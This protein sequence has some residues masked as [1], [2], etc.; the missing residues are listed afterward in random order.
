MNTTDNLRFHSAYL[1]FDEDLVMA[2]IYPHGHIGAADMY[3]FEIRVFCWHL[4]WQV[5]T[6]VQISSSLSQ[7]FSV[8]EHIILGHEEHSQ[9]SEE[10]NQV[11]RAEWRRLLSLFRNVKT[12][13]IADGLVE[14]L[15]RCLELGNGELP[16]ELLPELQE[17][18]YSGSG[19]AGDAFTSFIDARNTD[20][21][22]SLVRRGPGP[23]LDQRSSVPITQ[24]K[25]KAGGDLD[26]S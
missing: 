2:K 24:A 18:T 22:I 12:I 10:H 17:L 7:M 9:S 13:Q 11:E 26:E 4:D 25:N 15:S 3:V 14:D 20:R 6:M 8:V 16:L 1:L 23:S 5:S 19:D 21:P